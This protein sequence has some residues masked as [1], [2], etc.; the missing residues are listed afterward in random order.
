MFFLAERY[1]SGSD[2]DPAE[3]N[4]A[5]ARDNFVQ[6]TDEDTEVVTS[7][8]RTTTSSSAISG[9]VFT[10]PNSLN[11]L[12]VKPSGN[13]I[14]LK[15]QAKGEPEPTIEW[16]KDGQ[17]IERKMGQVLY[18][19]WKVELRRFKIPQKFKLFAFF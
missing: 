19:K 3:I 15:C 1:T 13:M 2:L 18:S 14:N 5:P 9:P 6:N 11:R 12:V 7:P 17:K 8:T 4:E 10:N 16:T